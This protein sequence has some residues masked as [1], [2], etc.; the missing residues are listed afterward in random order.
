MA[1][2]EMQR[3]G[4][5][6]AND[7]AQALLRTAGNE[8]LAHGPDPDSAVIV[9]TGFVLAVERAATADPVIL[10]LVRAMLRE[11]A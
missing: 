8:L 3:A 10:R 5:E 11:S 2:T 7:L 6:A 4:A 9:A 1:L